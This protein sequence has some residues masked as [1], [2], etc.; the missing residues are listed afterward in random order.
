MLNKLLSKLGVRKCEQ[1]NRWYKPKRENESFCSFWCV[2]H[3]LID[4][5]RDASRAIDEMLRELTG[6]VQDA[7]DEAEQANGDDLKGEL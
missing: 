7:I 3:N 6:I 5:A 1:C 4:E 2:A